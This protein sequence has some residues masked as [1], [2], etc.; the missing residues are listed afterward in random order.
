MTN[1][2]NPQFVDSVLE[3]K[4]EASLN[5]QIQKDLELPEG[6]SIAELLDDEEKQK[7]E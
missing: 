5:D 7:Q 6:K 3:T 2:Q 4:A 1:D